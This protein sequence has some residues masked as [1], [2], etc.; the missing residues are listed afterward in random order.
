MEQYK[1]G[2]IWFIESEDSYVQKQQM[3][4]I[5]CNGENLLM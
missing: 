2:I 1:Q 3:K 5:R 4:N